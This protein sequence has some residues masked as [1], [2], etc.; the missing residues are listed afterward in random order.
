MDQI[1]DQV[2]HVHETSRLNE[3]GSVKSKGHE[4]GVDVVKHAVG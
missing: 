4:V 2:A 1:A 3:Q